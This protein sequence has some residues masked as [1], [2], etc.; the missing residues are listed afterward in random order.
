MTN[1][2]VDGILKKRRFLFLSSRKNL[3]ITQKTSK[4]TLV[5][6]FTLKPFLN[7]TNDARHLT[8]T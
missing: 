4:P 8:W 5:N 2:T 1:E 7:P 3:I 6:L